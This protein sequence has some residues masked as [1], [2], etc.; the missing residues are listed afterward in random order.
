MKVVVTNYL[1]YPSYYG[2]LILSP[3]TESTWKLTI[4]PVLNENC[5]FRTKR[6]PEFFIRLW[7][8]CQGITETE[9]VRKQWRT[10]KGYIE[11]IN[12]VCNLFVD[13]CLGNSFTISS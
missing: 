12:Y 9:R 2:Y 11:L 4:I 13:N 7:K 6:D 8:K 3:G 1:K 10:N 5:L